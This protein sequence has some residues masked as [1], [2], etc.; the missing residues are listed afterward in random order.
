MGNC[1]LCVLD[2][3][4]PFPIDIVTRTDTDCF[5]KNIASADSAPGSANQAVQMAAQFI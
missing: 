4:E 1:Q 5:N 2:T 3:L